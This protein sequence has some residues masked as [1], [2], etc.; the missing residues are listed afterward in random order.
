MPSKSIN[1]FP[2]LE[3]ERLVLRYLNRDDLEFVYKHF[4]DPNV[5]RY[6][7]DE[8][9]VSTTAEAEEII[10]EY[11]DPVGKTHNRWGIVLK[12]N[13][14]LVGTCGFHKWDLSHKRAEVGYDLGPDFWG[15]GIMKE[16]LSEAFRHG[17]TQMD[18]N[19]IDALV[20][21]EN[22]RSTGLLTALGFRQEGVLREYFLQAGRYYDHAIYSLLRS[23][24][25]TTP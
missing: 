25:T 17:F 12:S 14:T 6:L 24:F 10:N 19:R 4:S 8:N 16:A 1:H 21:A 23:E 11:L 18:L 9:P 5:C 7:L 13:K 22:E 15:Q 20:Y 3:T 2:E